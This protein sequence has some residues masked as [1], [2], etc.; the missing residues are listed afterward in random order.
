[1]TFTCLP[2]NRKPPF[3]SGIRNFILTF[4]RCC[5]AFLVYII[6][7]AVILLS[8]ADLGSI[9]LSIEL[10]SFSLYIISSIHRNSESSTGSALTYFLLGGLSSCFILLGIAL[11][12]ANSGL[13]NLDSIYSIISD[14]KVIKRLLAYSTIS[15]IGFILMALIVHTIESYQA[16]FF[17]LIQYILTNLNAFMIIVAIGFTLYLYYTNVSEYNNLPEKNNSPIQLINQLKGYFSIN[18]VLALCFVVTMFSF[19]GLPPLVGFF[20]KQLVLTTALDNSKIILVLLSVFTSVIGAVYY[21][22]IIKTIYFEESE[23]IKPTIYVENSLSNAYS[24]TL[25]ILNLL[26]IYQY[27]DFYDNDEEYVEF[28][29]YIIPESDL[30]IGKLRML[31]VDNRVIIPELTHTR[32]V[33]AGADVIHSYATPA[34]GIKCDAYPG[35]LNQSSV[36]LNREGTYF[37]QCSEICGILH[38]SMPIAIQSVGLGKL[39]RCRSVFISSSKLLIYKNSCKS[40]VGDCLLTIGM[41]AILFSFGDINYFTVFSL[42]PY[43]SETVIIVIGPTPV[44][45][46]IHAATM[47]TAVFSSLIGLFQQD[48]KKVIAY[49]TMSQLGMMIIAVGAGAVIHAVADNQDFRKYGGLITYLPLSYSVMLIASLSLVAF[50]FMTGFYSKDLI[51]ESAYG[52]YNLSSIIVYFIATIGAMFTTLYSVKVLYITFL[53]NPNGPLVNYV[54]KLSKAAHEGDIFMSMP[55][56]ILAIVTGVTLGMHYTPNIQEAFDSVEHIM[57]DVNNG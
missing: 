8:S 23:Y 10:Q 46:L 51:L 42:S 50:P 48:I 4:C 20:A 11:I 54:S 45:A 41:F 55:L 22:T 26:V 53:S 52:Q 27:P 29:S 15:H 33:V 56:I 36:Y 14:T 38:S 37:G 30:D 12:Y 6:S 3:G 35:R 44:S 7:G 2:F 43:F 28:D 9:Y 21:L 19:I 34:L 47:V 17:Y 40:K 16:F 57:R 24:I 18:P 39:G 31:E 1:M 49:S 32:F 5:M 25:S 13:T